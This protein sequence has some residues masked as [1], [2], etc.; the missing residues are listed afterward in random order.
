MVAIL[1]VSHVQKES[2]DIAPSAVVDVV[3]YFAVPPVFSPWES[4]AGTLGHFPPATACMR[5]NFGH[6][7]CPDSGRH[8]TVASD[9]CDVG[10]RQGSSG[11]AFAKEQW[12]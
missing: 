3:P 9:G 8:D 1:I 11:E 10:H 4:A 5:G 7:H 2:K 12:E 6:V